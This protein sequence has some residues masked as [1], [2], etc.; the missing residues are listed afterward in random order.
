MCIHIQ[1]MNIW[2]VQKQKLKFLFQKRSYKKWFIV[3]PQQGQKQ[4]SVK[5]VEF[6]HLGQYFH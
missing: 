6:I 5:F 2:T 3:L 1:V 4:M